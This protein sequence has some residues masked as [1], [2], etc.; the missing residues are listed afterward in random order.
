MPWGVLYQL[1]YYAVVAAVVPPPSLKNVRL[2]GNGFLRDKVE[3]ERSRRETTAILIVRTLR[4]F[5]WTLK[6]I[7]IIK[8][9]WKSV[10]ATFL[11]LKKTPGRCLRTLPRNLVC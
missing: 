9:R 5:F 4:F 6:K 2:G 8:N 3:D 11:G 7:K 10:A 1:G